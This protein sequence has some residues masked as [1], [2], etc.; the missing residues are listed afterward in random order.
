ME[1][2][3]IV[4]DD[5]GVFK[6]YLHVKH[7]ENLFTIFSGSVIGSK[8]ERAYVYLTKENAQELINELKTFINQ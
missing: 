2:K 1:Y 4:K 5:K 8:E 7:N 6:H 3:T